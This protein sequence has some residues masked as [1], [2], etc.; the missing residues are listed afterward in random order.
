MSVGTSTFLGGQTQPTLF[1]ANPL[2]FTFHSLPFFPPL[3][4]LFS[5]NAVYLVHLGGL[6]ITGSFP[7]RVCSRAPAAKAYILR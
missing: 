2:L 6:G 5:F 3:F 4:F 1:G 7:C